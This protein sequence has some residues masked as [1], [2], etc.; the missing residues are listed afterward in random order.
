MIKHAGAESAESNIC[1]LMT[2]MVISIAAAQNRK[3]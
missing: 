1:H 3:P 2:L